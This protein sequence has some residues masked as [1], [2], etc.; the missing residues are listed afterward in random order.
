MLLSCQTKKVRKRH[1]IISSVVVKLFFVEMDNISADIIQKALIVRNDQKSFL[2]FLQIT[3]GKN[4]LDI[5]L[6]HNI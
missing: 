4:Q 5:L 2:P 3:E 6:L 1:T